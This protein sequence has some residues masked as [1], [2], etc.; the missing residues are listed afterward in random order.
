MSTQSDQDQ[1]DGVEVAVRE[2]RARIADHKPHI[3][4]HETR[5]R[6]LL[7]DPILNSLG[8]NVLDPDV[9]EFETPNETGIPDYV[10]KVDGR[11]SMLVESKALGKLR[12][13]EAAGQ[14]AGYIWQPFLVTAQ[15]GILTDGDHWQLR[16]KP[17]VMK[18]TKPKFKISDSKVE[19]HKMAS[20]LYWLLARSQ[21]GSTIEPRVH[22]YAL[23]EQ[24]SFPDGMKPKA[25]RIDGGDPIPTEHW[26]ELLV[27]LARHLINT[28]ALTSSMIPLVTIGGKKYLVNDSGT[29]WNGKDFLLPKEVKP[30]FWVDGLGG[31][32]GIPAKCRRLINAVR[33]GRMTVEISFEPVE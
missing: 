10:L 19:A 2:V 21:M 6:I 28:G 25:I 33:A 32:G 13:T 26:Y 18:P 17:N 3:S 23:D 15:A 8:W 7:V 30:G 11:P 27:E 9:V 31:V 4:N 22:W 29:Q 20:D 1:I 14:V 16:R 5:T 12:V 24:A